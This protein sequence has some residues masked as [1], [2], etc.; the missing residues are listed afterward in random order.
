MHLNAVDPNAGRAEAAAGAGEHAVSRRSFLRAAGFAFA[1]A[2]VAGCDRAL[3]HRIVPTLDQPEGLTPGRALHYASTCGGCTAGCG[4]VAKTRDGRP[5]KLEGNRDHPVSRGGLC[6]VGQAM[7]LSL[8]DSQRLDHPTA[9]RERSSWADVDRTITQKLA[10]IREERGAV[11][12]L[13]CSITSPTTRAVIERF[14]GSF[15]DGRLVEVDALSASAILDAHLRTH[16]VRALPR[17]HFERAEL[18]VSFDADFLGT[19]I[20]PVEFTAGWRAG[21]VLDNHPHRMST[22]VQVESRLSLTGAKADERIPV[23]P[24]EIAGLVGGLAGLVGARA[25]RR[26]V[27][28]APEA[29]ATLGDLADRLWRARGR[30][31]VVSGTNDAGVQAAINAVNEALGAY[32]TTLDIEEPSYQRR[33]D[34]SEVADLVGQM[35]AGRI[36]ALL[37]HGC[38]PVY[39]LPDALGFAEALEKVPLSVGFADR[40]DET[41]SL[42]SYDCPDHHPLESW[43][44]AEPV[45]GVLTVTQPTVRPLRGTR[46][47]RESLTAWTGA[48]ERRTDRD[49]LRAHWRDHLFPRQSAH[50]TF[51]GFWD[52]TVRQGFAV[53]AA[54][55]ALRAFDSS[56]EI[57]SPAARVGSGMALVLYP[58]VAMH[59]GQHA[60][61]PWLHELPDPITKVV[62]DNYASLAPVTARSR[63]IEQGDIVKV[64]VGERRIELPA[65]IQPGQH[66]EVVAI[67]LGYGRMGTDRFAGIGPEWLQGRPTVERG[68]TVG[69]RAAGLAVLRDGAVQ[70]PD[71][72]VEVAKTRR[73][74]NLACTQDH[75]QIEEP[76]EI[77]GERRPVVQ[78][79]GF[80][81]F[82]AGERP[83]SH[84]EE[85][86]SLWPED[87]PMR[88]HHWGMVVDLSACTGC[89]ACVIGCQAENNVPVVGKDEVARH[90]EMHWMRIDRY[91]ADEAG[92]IETLMQPLMCQHCENAPCETVCPVLAT[93]HSSEGLNQQV[94]N[95]C[96]GTRYCANN[97]PFKTR[98]FNWFD[99]R[100]EDRMENMVLNPEVTIRTRGVMEK[101]SMCV[102]RIQEA[103]HEARRLGTKITDGEVE[104]ACQES[105]PSRAIAFGD[106]NDPDSEVSRLRRDPRN[107]R[108]LEEIE[109]RPSVSYLALVRPGSRGGRH[110]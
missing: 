104:T 61:S 75:H 40:L 92:R 11:R 99:Y 52:E 101:C 19:W 109:V 33:G 88:G 76:K 84:E 105:C 98:R 53:L 57:P 10:R 49:I 37:V 85:L 94:Y 86:R 51:D 67:P 26:I 45:A 77:G 38:N 63:G 70:L 43:D 100:H 102:Q 6:A 71:V 3:T 41:T 79:L 5:I 16:G 108:A 81:A 27:T 110:G 36:A 82:E 73:R 12:I 90:R 4:I 55:R 50:P 48:G 1:G 31:L 62:W 24:D 20:S 95:R 34:D 22:V 87:H 42:T 72:E 35:R 2:A 46:A 14:L 17:Y 65:H 18:I 54:E 74:V 32:G 66:P 58:T 56:R 9:G 25:G 8:Y 106:L 30:A 89:S 80:A 13:S 60:H 23:R 21:R 39:E 28:G 96:V 44:D 59:A 78:E 103:K 69:T 47:L 64:T 107:Y 83:E 7:V 91:Y 15:A 29:D 68:Q 93:V 97:C